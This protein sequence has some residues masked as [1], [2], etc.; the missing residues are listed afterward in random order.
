MFCFNHDFFS[1]TTT[2]RKPEYRPEQGDEGGVHSPWGQVYLGSP[3]PGLC[4]LLPGSL[5]VAQAGQEQD[6]AVPTCSPGSLLT[7]ATLQGEAAPLSFAGRGFPKLLPPQN[8]SGATLTLPSS[9]FTWR[10]KAGSGKSTRVLPRPSVSLQNSFSLPLLL[11][12]RSL[13]LA[14][15][16]R[17][18]TR[19]PNTPR[20][21]ESKEEKSW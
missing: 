20:A 21:Q 12:S 9:L 15:G 7:E 5:A 4:L 6:T 17:F 10:G 19:R 2:E 14:S 1:L 13:S 11:G 3:Q 18:G 8:R 16:R